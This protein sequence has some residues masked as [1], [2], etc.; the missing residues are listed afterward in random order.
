MKRITIRIWQMI[1]SVFA[2]IAF[3]TPMAFGDNQ[4]PEGVEQVWT[5]VEGNIT[6]YVKP[7]DKVKKGDPLFLVVTTD[8][9]PEIFFQDLHSIE[10]YKIIFGRRD[11]L[12]NTKA[13]SQE[14]FDNALDDLVDAKDSLINYFFK[15]KTGFYVAP[16]DCEI[17]KLLYINGSGIGD[18]NPAINIKCTDP[19]NKYNP[20]KPNQKMLDLIKFS[21]YMLKKQTEALDVKQLMDS[22][23]STNM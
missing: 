3:V 12:L 17:V 15:F 4:L 16:Y 5:A 19:N 18:G 1:L 6:Y 2:F 23:Q 11:K 9:N 20:P 14:D 8:A 7:G 21:D 13:V 10:Y 22:I